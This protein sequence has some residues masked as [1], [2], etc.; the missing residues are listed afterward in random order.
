[1]GSI[2]TLMTDFGLSGAPAVMKGVILSIAPAVTL[3]DVTHTVAPQNIAQGARILGYCAPR[4]PPGAIHVCVVDP[5]VGTRRRPIAA[6][7]ESQVFVGPDNGLITVLHNQAQ[8]AG[9]PIGIYHLDQ[10]R[11]WLPKVSETFHGRDIFAPAAAHLAA[12]AALADVGSR[13]SDPV[14]LALPV[15]E[16]TPA[17]LRGE[18]VHVDAFG[19]LWTNITAEFL[20]GLNPAA[21][22]IRE[23]VIPGLVRTFGERAPG[24]LIAYI[25]SEDALSVAVVNGSA[26]RRLD[27]RAGDPIEVTGA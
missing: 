21:V 15:P 11:Y 27:A 22:R 4:F 16:R 5:G 2:I 7:L 3:V 23:T 10:P 14:L 6:R 13:V 20:A 12:G 18:V 25:N 1:M 26:A 17:D 8:R 9:A 19:N 24:E